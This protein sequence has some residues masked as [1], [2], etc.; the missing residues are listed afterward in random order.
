[1][2]FTAKGF[3]K[4]DGEQQQ[5]QQQQQQEEEW[6]WVCSCLGLLGLQLT[7][8]AVSEPTYVR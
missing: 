4:E 7:A 3:G 2:M 6:G 5:Q 1:M 8:R